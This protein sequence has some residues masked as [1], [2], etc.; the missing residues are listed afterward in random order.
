MRLLNQVGQA[1]LGVL[2]QWPNQVSVN[3]YW[4]EM[5]LGWHPD[6]DDDVGQTISTLSL[7]GNATVHIRL[8]NSYYRNE[9]DMMNEDPIVGALGW[10]NLT[11]WRRRWQAGEIEDEEYRINPEVVARSIGRTRPQIDLPLIHG[12]IAI[13]TGTALTK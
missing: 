7:G 6:G 12:S 2:Y 10:K 4:S 11:E 8:Q 5:G 1:E 9:I 3:G 13:M